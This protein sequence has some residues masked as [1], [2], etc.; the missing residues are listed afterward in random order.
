M[1]KWYF[2]PLSCKKNYFKKQFLK[3]WHSLEFVAPKLA[4]LLYH[5][6]RNSS[7]SLQLTD[8]KE[9]GGVQRG[10]S[11]PPLNTPPGG[12]ADKR[13]V[14]KSAFTGERTK[15][16]LWGP[17]SINFLRKFLYGN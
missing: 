7:V 1:Y 4:E 9:A 12:T 8:R 6:H 5:W 3:S 16:K 13:T 14:N 11:F 17:E 10:L 2:S 15:M